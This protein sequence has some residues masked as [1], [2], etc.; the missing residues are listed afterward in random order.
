MDW[1]DG[2]VHERILNLDF[3]RVHDAR[4]PISEKALR[5]GPERVRDV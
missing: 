3:V 1:Y 2:L 4:I 5:I